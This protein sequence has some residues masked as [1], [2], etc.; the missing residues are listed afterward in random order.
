METLLFSIAAVVAVVSASLMILQRNPMFSA[1]YLIL[2]LLSIAV[3]YV[4]L[5]AQFVAVM[6]I[7]VYAGAIMVLFLFVIM[8]L[9]QERSIENP[10]PLR[11]QNP[12]AWI[13][14]LLLFGELLWL[15]V[16]TPAPVSSAFPSPPTPGAFLGSV[17]AIGESLFTRYL[18]PF[19]LTSVL[20]LVGMVGVIVLAKRKL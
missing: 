16:R 17:E 9:H 1:L 15:T 6:Q 3:L 8:L 2:T 5:G 13:M 20:L 7:I 19:E 11:L 12:I 14:G 18:F 4:Q 10:S